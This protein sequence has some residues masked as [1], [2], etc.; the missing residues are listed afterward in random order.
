[1]LSHSNQSQ[2]RMSRLALKNAATDLA[3]LAKICGC[4]VVCVSC[5]GIFRAAASGALIVLY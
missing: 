3:N 5:L 1:M 4:V 2:I